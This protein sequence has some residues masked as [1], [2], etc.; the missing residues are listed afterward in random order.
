MSNLN[1]ALDRVRRKKE[2]RER[3]EAGLADLKRRIAEL[4]KKILKF[5][6]AKGMGANS[7]S[8]RAIARKRSIKTRRAA[9]PICFL[10]A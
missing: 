3:M 2:E 6:R 9:R 8:S 1:E 7:V 10:R 4:P 5:P